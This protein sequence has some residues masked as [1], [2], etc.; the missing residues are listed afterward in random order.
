MQIA[1]TGASGFV[2]GAVATE[3][4]RQGHDVYAFGRRHAGSMSTKLP[5]YRQWN[6]RY[7]LEQRP[8]VEAVVHCAALVGDW[9]DDA[10]YQ[11]TNVRGTQRVLDT[12]RDVERFIHVSSASV[13]SFSPGVTNLSENAMTG[14]GLL[15]AYARSKADA[16]ALVMTR[17][18]D[19]VVLR[20]HIVYGPGDNTLMP[21]VIAARRFDCLAVPGNGRNRVSV[22]HIL[23]LTHAVMC[24][25]ECGAATGFFNIAD[26]EAVSID[27]L[28][29]TLLLRE[30][31]P[32]KLVHLPRRLAWMLASLAELLWRTFGARHAPRL[33]RYLV[34]QVAYGHTL[35]ISRAV[36]LLAYDPCYDYRSSI[37]F[38]ESR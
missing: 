13:Y 32:T 10:E 3:L 33:S 36:D 20:P 35:D 27:E 9:G 38:Q 7:P 31:Y 4:V 17:R 1:V 22:T 2:G 24:A 8:A 28:L 19:A 11:H 23:N 5:N 15:T 37:G 12:F 26:R 34:Q 6:I 29:Q 14:A 16:E 30:G 25:I 21:R 18:P